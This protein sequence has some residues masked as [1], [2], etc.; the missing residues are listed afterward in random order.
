MFCIGRGCL[1]FLRCLC[2]SCGGDI[3]GFRELRT[4][5]SLLRLHHGFARKLGMVIQIAVAASLPYADIDMLTHELRALAS[6]PP[7]AVALLET[8]SSCESFIYSY[9]EF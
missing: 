1:R 3:H 7:I 6:L 2:S 4:A 5:P 9:V 8:K